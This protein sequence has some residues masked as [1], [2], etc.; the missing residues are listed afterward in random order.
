MFY[1]LLFS[2]DD[3]RLSP[4]KR[5]IS[6]KLFYLF[7]C[8]VLDGDSGRSMRRYDG[9]GEGTACMLQSKHPWMQQVGRAEGDGTR[10][11]TLGSGKSCRCPK[12]IWVQSCV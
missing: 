5:L 12:W 2:I 1:T 4:F 10:G 11:G 8:M 6:P 9:E 3:T 7:C